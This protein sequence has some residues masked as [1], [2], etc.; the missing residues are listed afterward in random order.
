GLYALRREVAPTDREGVLG[1][2][3]SVQIE[4]R[5]G[6][7][8]IQRMYLGGEDVSE[9]IRRHEISS[10]ASHISAL[11]EVRAFLMETQRRLAAEHDVVMDGRD[12][13]TVVLPD[14]DV[15]IFLT[16]EPAARSHRRYEELRQ[17]GQ[18]T[19]YETVLRDLTQR[20]FDDTNRA[21]APL[22]QAA[23]AVL[24]DTTALSLDESLELLKKTV[25]ERLSR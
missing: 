1:L 19:D 16:A 20:D 21:A 24:A 11:P 3:D 17:R 10:Y 5:H 9:E 2:L 25:E 18:E 15:K 4:L 12:I 23:D 7:D 22:R 14:A 8:G 6:A 13:G